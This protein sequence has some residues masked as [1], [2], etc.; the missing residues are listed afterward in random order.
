MRPRPTHITVS[1]VDLTARNGPH[2]C[3]FRC[4]EDD[5]NDL[6]KAAESMMLSTAQFVRM[7]VIQAA[8]KVLAEH[9]A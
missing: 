5:K 1:L 6:D 2:T 7:I 4:S 8:R 3:I 9:T